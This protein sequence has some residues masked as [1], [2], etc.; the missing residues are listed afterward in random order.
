MG[1]GGCG[2]AIMKRALFLCI[3]FFGLLVGAA[4]KTWATDMVRLVNGDRLSGEVVRM[5][6][7]ELV[8]FIGSL[9]SSFS[10]PKMPF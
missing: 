9:K 6:K 3:P 1:A 7:S 5:E 10:T 8:S 2:K 4:P